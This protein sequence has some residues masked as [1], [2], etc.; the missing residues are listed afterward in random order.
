MGRWAHCLFG[1]ADA[2][3]RAL[4]IS[5]DIAQ[6]DEYQFAH[7]MNQTLSNCPPGVRG[8]YVKEFSLAE[9]SGSSDMEESMNQ[10]IRH[11]LDS[12]LGDELF[13]K[14]CAAEQH[15]FDFDDKSKY[16]VVVFAAMMMHFGAMIKEGHIQHLRNL[17]PKLQ[18]NEGAV[19]PFDDSGFR[20][21][22]K[23]QFLAALD[24][25]QAGK[26][27][28]FQEPS[29]HGCG[30]INDDIKGDGKL[31]QKCGG[32]KNERAVAWFCDKVCQR[33]LWKHHKPNCGTPLGRGVAIFRSYG[34]GSFGLIAYEGAN[35]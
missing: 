29:C 15:I 23:R 8:Y 19:M 31:L 12:G 7:I 22:G 16:V 26:P 1:H 9:K 11:K 13:E 18:C 24:H 2:I 20:G 5:K 14:Y 25:Y 17:V 10:L 28:S 34:K 33:G 32:C 30:K 6:G 27:R 3:G 21:P 4:E 35:V